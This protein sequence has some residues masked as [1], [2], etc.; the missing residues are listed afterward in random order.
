MFFPSS[1]DPFKSLNQ[2]EQL[3]RLEESQKAQTDQLGKDQADLGRIKQAADLDKAALAPFS[4]LPQKKDE[5]G[6]EGESSFDSVKPHLSS[7]SFVHL[8][9]ARVANQ[10]TYTERS[11]QSS[12]SYPV[13][14]ASVGIFQSVLNWFS[15]FSFS[16]A[17]EATKAHVGPRIHQ[18]MENIESQHF[19][20]DGDGFRKAVQKYAA[21]EASELAGLKKGKDRL[22][23]VGR[24][25]QGMILRFVAEKDPSQLKEG[26]EQSFTAFLYTAEKGSEGRQSA[27]LKD[28]KLSV[29]PFY[30]FQKIPA[31]KLYYER[32]ENKELYSSTLAN[33]ASLSTR[34]VSSI[35]AEDSSE[36]F[37]LLEDLLQYQV[38]AD[39]FISHFMRQQRSEISSQKSLNG[40][41]LHLCSELY[42]NEVEEEE[43]SEEV[44]KNQQNQSRAE[45]RRLTLQSRLVSLAAF[46]EKSQDLLDLPE[47]DHV[48]K[49]LRDGANNLLVAIYKYANHVD[50]EGKPLL[51]K[52]AA[53]TLRATALAVQER[54]E[55]A[56]EKALAISQQTY[57]AIKPSLP[58]NAAASESLGHY[59][60]IGAGAGYYVPQSVLSLPKIPSFSDAE[61]IIEEIDTYTDGLIPLIQKAEETDSSKVRGYNH[62]QVALLSSLEQLLFQIPDPSDDF[63]STSFAK[64]SPKDQKTVLANIQYFHEIYAQTLRRNEV[65]VERGKTVNSYSY[66]RPQTA[67][68]QVALLNFYAITHRIAVAMDRSQG[69]N[70]LED[71]PVD[72][73][74]FKKALEKDFT[75]A[76]DEVQL[77]EKRASLFQYF[78]TLSAQAKGDARNLFS[79]KSLSLQ[80]QKDSADRILYER[81]LKLRNK[82]D[83][84]DQKNPAIVNWGNNLFIVSSPENAL[85]GALNLDLGEPLHLV[86]GQGELMVSEIVPSLLKEYPHI[87]YLKKASIVNATL[88]APEA[89]SSSKVDFSESPQVHHDKLK[90]TLSSQGLNIEKEPSDD[91]KDASM[92]Y[93]KQDSDIQWN[94]VTRRKKNKYYGYDQVTESSALSLKTAYSVNPSQHSSQNEALTKKEETIQPAKGDQ[95]DDQWDPLAW[96]LA[97]LVSFPGLSPLNLLQWIRQHPDVLKSKEKREQIELLFFRPY[98]DSSGKEQIALFN[99]LKSEPEHI[100]PQ[101]RTF[102]SESITR[103]YLSKPHQRPDVESLV[104][105]LRFA[106]RIERNYLSIH[107]Q[108]LT[109]PLY[110]EKYLEE[111]FHIH[112]EAPPLTDSE[113]SRLS[114]CQFSHYF[115]CIDP[116]RLST[117]DLVK[118][119]KAWT[120]ISR[121]GLTEIGK[122]KDYDFKQTDE[123]QRG[124]SQLA[125]EFLRRCEE[126]ESFAKEFSDLIN[127]EFELPV[128]PQWAVQKKDGQPIPALMGKT[129]TG[130]WEMDLST[131][132]I[133]CNNTPLSNRPPSLYSSDKAIWNRLFGNRIFSYKKASSVYYFT[134]DLTYGSCRVIQ[135]SS[136]A[137]IERKLGDHW[138][139]AMHQSQINNYNYKFDTI[140]P[141][142]L[143][144]GYSHWVPKGDVKDVSLLICDLSTGKPKFIQDSQG[145]LHS[146]KVPSNWDG[147]VDALERTGIV[148]REPE[149]TVFHRLDK[150]AGN[151]FLALS[152]ET[153]EGNASTIRFER[154]FTP[155]GSRLRFFKKEGRWLYGPNPSWAMADPQVDGLFRHHNHYLLLH[156][157]DKKGKPTGRQ[158]IL[159]LQPQVKSSGP[160]NAETL[161]EASSYYK[162][163]S[164]DVTLPQGVSSSAYSSKI[165]FSIPLWNSKKSVQDQTLVIREFSIRDGSVTA[166]AVEDKLYLSLQLLAGKDY[167]GAMA[168][169]R[170]IGEA[171]SLNDA[172]KQFLIDLLC[173]EKSCKDQSP[174]ASAVRL[175]AAWVGKTLEPTMPLGKAV[176]GNHRALSNI[177]T[178]YLEGFQRVPADVALSPQEEKDLIAFFRLS[179][180]TRGRD[181]VLEGTQGYAHK[182]WK[183]D[184]KAL[185]T[186]TLAWEKDPKLPHLSYPIK[187]PGEAPEVGKH[188][189]QYRNWAAKQDSYNDNLKKIR[190]YFISTSEDRGEELPL[191]GDTTITMGMVRK[192]YN[193]L[194]DPQM[195]DREKRG[196]YDH[197]VHFFHGEFDSRNTKDEINIARLNLLHCAYTYGKKMPDFPS[198][199]EK[200]NVE[201]WEAFLNK[202][203]EN[204]SSALPGEQTSRP[205]FTFIKMGGTM[206]KK[207]EADKLEQAEGREASSQALSTALLTPK[208]ID[209]D[210]HDFRLTY[211]KD[212]KTVE[213]P[214]LKPLA[215]L[216]PPKLSKKDENVREAI[217]REFEK[218]NEDIQTS[219]DQEKNR[220]QY[221][222][223]DDKPLPEL[224]AALGEKLKQSKE[225]IEVKEEALVLL[226]KQKDVA[227]SPE[228]KGHIES[229]EIKDPSIHDILRASIKGTHEAYRALN[230]YL[231][232]ERIEE[233]HQRAIELMTYATTTQQLSGAHK[234]LKASEEALK[235]A[236]KAEGEEQKAL[237]A[238]ADTLKKEG[239]DILTATRNY[240]LENA[241]T[242]TKNI[243]LL[244]FEYKTGMRIRFKQKE[245]LSEILNKLEKGEHPP[246]LIFQLIMGGGKTSVILSFLLDYVA[247]IQGPEGESK[248]LST[249]MLD[250]ALFDGI[251]EN[252]K[253]YHWERFGKQLIPL[254]IQRENLQTAEDVKRLLDKI[255][256]AKREK[257]ALAVTSVDL[258]KILLELKDTAFDFNSSSGD[259]KKNVDLTRAQY[260]GEILCLFP[261]QAVILTDEPDLVYLINKKLIFSKGKA[262]HLSSGE[263]KTQRNLFAEIKKK[264][265]V[266]FS[267][268][269]AISEETYIEKVRPQLC[270]FS[271]KENKISPKHRASYT[272]YLCN[273]IKLSLERPAM[274]D[275][276]PPEFADLAEANGGED[277]FLN[278]MRTH[279]D[280]EWLETLRR[281]ANLD[282]GQW[283]ALKQDVSDWSYLRYLHVELGQSGSGKDLEK[284]NAQATSRFLIYNVLKGVL[285]K[286]PNRHFGFDLE[287]NGMIRPFTG[288]DNPATTQLANPQEAGSALFY[289]MLVLG[290]QKGFVKYL[291]ETMAVAAERNAFYSG[292]FDLTEEAVKF[293]EMT[294]VSLSLARYGKGLDEATAFLEKEENFD[295]LLEFTSALVHIHVDYYTSFL[296]SDAY[297]IPEFG[298]AN[299]TCTGTPGS[300]DTFN[301]IDTK[302]LDKGTLGKIIHHVRSKSDNEEALVLDD[303]KDRIES[304]LQLIEDNDLNALMDRGGLVK[305]TRKGEKTAGETFARAYLERFIE[306]PKRQSFIFFDYTDPSTGEVVPGPAILKKRRKTAPDGKVSWVI[307]KKPISLKDTTAESLRNVGVVDLSTMFVFFSETKTTGIDFKLYPTC[308]GMVTI[309][310][311]EAQGKRQGEERTLQAILRMRGLFY[312]QQVQFV[313]AQSQVDSF[314]NLFEMG[315]EQEAPTTDQVFEFL[316]ANDG[317]QKPEMTT[318]SL[319]ERVGHCT[320]SQVGKRYAKLASESPQDL[321]AFAKKYGKYLYTTISD[322]ALHRVGHLEGEKETPQCI[323]ELIREERDKIKAFGDPE[324]ENAIHESLN[325]L[326]TVFQRLKEEKALT[327]KTA[328]PSKEFS[329]GNQMQVSMQQEQE[330]KAELTQEQEQKIDLE[331]F[332]E[333]SSFQKPNNYRPAKEK[334]WNI[335]ETLQG[336]LPLEAG[337]AIHRAHDYFKNNRNKYGRDYHLAFSKELNLFFSNNFTR[338]VADK[339]IAVFD[340]AHKKIRHLLVCP[341]VDG[342]PGLMA[343]SDQDYTKW[344]KQIQ[345]WKGECP[346]HIVDLDGQVS[347]GGIKDPKNPTACSLPPEIQDSEDYQRTLWFANFFNGNMDYLEGHPEQS[348]AIMREEIEGADHLLRFCYFG[349]AYGKNKERRQ[350]LISSRTLNPLLTPKGEGEFHFGEVLSQSF[351]GTELLESEVAKAELADLEPEHVPTLAKQ[352][353]DRLRD[354]NRKDLIQAIPKDFINLI[355]PEKAPLLSHTQVPFITNHG[356]ANNLSKEQLRS[357][358]GDEGIR[359]LGLINLKTFPLENIPPSQ[360]TNIAL[361]QWEALSQRE[362]EE[363][364]EDLVRD[365]VHELNDSYNITQLPYDLKSLLK[366]EQVQLLDFKL[367]LQ[368]TPPDLANHFSEDQWGVLGGE[369]ANEESTTAFVQALTSGEHIAK[370][371]PFNLVK[372]L[373]EE[374]IPTIPTTKRGVDVLENLEDDRLLEA[375]SKQ[376]AALSPERIDRITNGELAIQIFRDRPEKARDLQFHIKRLVLMNIEPQATLHPWFSEKEI[377]QV[378]EKTALL[379]IPAVHAPLFLENQWNLLR[380][381]KKVPHVK[382]LLRVLSGQQ[383]VD[384]GVPSSLYGLLQQSQVQDFPATE[385]GKA[386]LNQ[387]PD[388]QLHWAKNEQLRTVNEERVRSIKNLDLANRFIGLGRG[389]ELSLETKIKVLK[390]L[391]NPESVDWITEDELRTI[392]DA[393]L[394][395]KFKD[396][397]APSFT[398]NQWKSLS[399]HENQD[400]VKHFV[401]QL[402]GKQVVLNELPSD[403]YCYL[404]EKQVQEIPCDMGRAVIND[405]PE[406][407]LLLAKEEQLRVLEKETI[408]K[409]RDLNLVKRMLRIN[410]TFLSQKIKES[411]LRL[412][413]TDQVSKEELGD[414]S[415]ISAKELQDLNDAGLNRFL[416]LF[417]SDRA[418]DFLAAQWDTL[419]HMNRSDKIVAFVATLSGEEVTNLPLP[420]AFDDLLS[421]SQI[422]GISEKTDNGKTILNRLPDKKLLE[423]RDEQIAELND[424]RIGQIQSPQLAQRVPL[425]KRAALNW[426]QK[427]ALLKREERQEESSWISN[428]EIDRLDASTIL[429]KLSF[430]RAN[431]FSEETWQLLAGESSDLKELKK[432]FVRELSP[433]KVLEVGLDPKLCAFLDQKQ[434]RDINKLP[435]N[436]HVIDSLKPGQLDWIKE[437]YILLSKTRIQNVQDLRVAKRLRPRDRKHLSTKM[438]LDLLSN[439]G[440]PTHLDWISNEEL[441]QINHGKDLLKLPANR[442][443]ALQ[444]NQWELLANVPFAEHKQT[445]ALVQALSGENVLKKE[446]PEALK[447]NLSPSQIR[448]IEAQNVPSEWFDSL[449]DEQLYQ[450]LNQTPVSLSQKR[451]GEIRHVEL[452]KR[453]PDNERVLLSGPMKIQLAK[454][455]ENWGESSKDWI[456]TDLLNEL[457]AETLRTKA[458]TERAVE[459]NSATWKKLSPLIPKD[460]LSDFFQTLSV[461]QIIEKKVPERFVNLYLNTEQVQGIDLTSPEQNSF[462]QRLNDDK[463]LLARDEQL[464]KLDEERVREIAN[465][466]L[467]K[468]ML[469]IQRQGDLPSEMKYLLLREKKDE[470]LFG[471][472][473]WLNTEEL[474]ALNEL[475]LNHHL[476]LC[477]QERAHEFLPEQWEFLKSLVHL[478]E[479]QS[480]FCELTGEEV[481][482][483][484]I[485]QEYDFYLTYDQIRGIPLNT[486]NGKQLLN[487][488]EDTRLTDAKREQLSVLSEERIA[489]IDSLQLAAKIPF[490]KRISLKEDLKI[491]FLK[492]EETC[493][494]SSWIRNEELNRLDARLILEKIPSNRAGDLSAEKWKELSK[495]ENTITNLLFRTKTDPNAK[496]AL[497]QVT[498]SLKAGKGP[499]EV[500][501][502]LEQKDERLVSKLKDFVEQLSPQQVIDKDLPKEVCAHLSKD[503]VLGVSKLP[504]HHQ[505]LSRLTPDQKTWIAEKAPTSHTAASPRR[506]KRIK[507]AKKVREK[508][509]QTG[510]SPAKPSDKS[511]GK[512]LKQQPPLFSN[513]QVKKP[514][515]P[516]VPPAVKQP[517]KS[518]PS[519]ISK[520]EAFVRSLISGSKT[521]QSLS[522]EEWNTLGSLEDPRVNSFIQNMDEQ[523]VL[524]CLPLLPP[525]VIQTLGLEQTKWIPETTN[526]GKRA[527]NLFTDQQLLYGTKEGAISVL[528]DD[529]IKAIRSVQVLIPKVPTSR[530]GVLRKETRIQILQ[531]A[532]VQTQIP[533]ISRDDLQSITD[534]QT[535]ATKIPPNRAKDLTPN[536]WKILLSNGTGAHLARGL[537]GAEV[538]SCQ[539][540]EAYYP[541]LLPDQ[542][543]GIPY[544][545]AEGQ[546]V[547]NKLSDHKLS[548][549]LSEQIKVLTPTR[550]GKITQLHIAYKA[551]QVGK[552]GELSS[553]TRILVL[554]YLQVPKEGQLDVSW[555]TTEDLRSI[556][557]VNILISKIPANRSR[558]FTPAQWN[559]LSLYPQN[560]KVQAFVQALTGREVASRVASKQIPLALLGALTPQQVKGIPAST[561]NGKL[562]L[563]QLPPEKLRFLQKSQINLAQESL[564]GRVESLNDT[565]RNQVLHANKSLI[566]ILKSSDKINAISNDLVNSLNRQQIKQ[567]NPPK[568]KYINPNRMDQLSK[569]Q[570][571]KLLG[572]EDVQNKPRFVAQIHKRSKVKAVPKHLLKHLPAKRDVIKGVS[573][574]RLRYLKL[575]QLN[576]RYYAHWYNYPL[577]II[578]GVGILAATPLELFGGICWH[579]AKMTGLGISRIWNRSEERKESVKKEAYRT[580]I[581]APFKPLLT[582]FLA[583]FHY[584]AYKMAASHF[585]PG[586]KNYSPSDD[587]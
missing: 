584:S 295:H 90:I 268:D 498:K 47:G 20:L 98:I 352:A 508:K 10:T 324:L 311:Q 272:R 154:V 49:M 306:D 434:V 120:E 444:K 309:N 392:E 60:T 354:L 438:K 13:H 526:A 42:E 557:N 469:L 565:R 409:I 212:P 456:S 542:I 406:D 94:S 457:E 29:K 420:Q 32:G 174:E 112:K 522:Q 177:Y 44:K 331:L 105:V 583:P 9:G 302:L 475:D 130:I 155:D 226:A 356:I 129:S 487:R 229:Y 117:K 322:Q 362:L 347:A 521:A 23:A 326:D 244:Y 497:D 351:L 371:L 298:L 540:P 158:K 277:S 425:K 532:P 423:S 89:S 102:V 15:S 141:Q 267:A 247:E 245:L 360:A 512:P 391:D 241:E 30:A 261:E 251:F 195:S 100:L 173:S 41:L 548:N 539:L 385:K 114:L 571:S 134:D 48:R 317:R 471:D 478:P 95:K 572:R 189:Q 88:M 220:E 294:G 162:P 427:S 421:S 62:A 555:V 254:R 346:Y 28:A 137:S 184:N 78:D 547:I 128:N 511:S 436:E 463:L 545:T 217:E 69:T 81:I 403:L 537:T 236:Q 285:T 31:S 166:D 355:L 340:P 235:E 428:E 384:N 379:R 560:P 501:Q 284:A 307:D 535:L 82:K 410:P 402:S 76:I 400:K 349:V 8:H 160:N 313:V 97:E 553:E 87:S 394:L 587:S 283:E 113:F 58:K 263:I 551:C 147:H 56:E 466:A 531:H 382:E 327:Q 213:A 55:E 45:F 181:Q 61:K 124:G 449:S 505:I 496:K 450:G 133:L 122:G 165:S 170:T 193:Q 299:I 365:L 246:Q 239:V 34:S 197:M 38:D 107:N 488:L 248:Y 441:K 445:K 528:T 472:L 168:T 455:L 337:V 36:I 258:Q 380:D 453:I 566:S 186:P 320:I 123:A 279:Y 515:Q 187:D 558:E 516:F 330:E 504:D 529:R 314:K 483:L 333:R 301:R 230:P 233:I 308:K 135:S 216:T 132:R 221:E 74:L 492:L 316:I 192:F 111:L 369:F 93:C 249:L 289:C 152:K 519:P 342:K 274:G 458:P 179:H 462:F 341:N 353:P 3:S 40:L 101:I 335:P 119:T 200:D 148:L 495:P 149:K 544:D 576:A 196:I 538:V 63:W 262:H 577:N 465:D 252:V 300:S 208:A 46:C 227:L 96:D 530:F 33:L 481:A 524:D 440:S 574:D 568:I 525:K 287:G 484:S 250:P 499:E 253:R 210:L 75:H 549:A 303:S 25:G 376:R 65:S 447:T 381:F 73:S 67:R 176:D 293:K 546:A 206:A 554:A 282:E 161:Y 364:E 383:V 415:W 377:Q 304:F 190:R 278:D 150:K 297:D 211:F 559:S 2:E 288:R 222:L 286:E 140:V 509:L 318:R 219:I 424:V 203:Y 7:S 21:N 461:E 275:Q 164:R 156:E 54:V 412:T 138:F 53:N 527:I 171:D 366:P 259:S 50:G 131:G 417:P 142:P 564:R 414:L 562:L 404:G 59:K 338:T 332:N 64:L 52:Q 473:S 319:K 80:P 513:K 386:S 446:L 315:E 296:S 18:L 146:V 5:E 323:E 452:A 228:K 435:G 418:H 367:C 373:S 139:A 136:K 350:Q 393:D 22:I 153:E 517:S 79:W 439:L 183:F 363:G 329:L 468:R 563:S 199:E 265:L 573:K 413:E 570:I 182:Q 580:F 321:P 407:R 518:Q 92:P 35:Q 325:Q 536:Q 378:E 198:F 215:P 157:L 502:D 486:E 372:H 209:A 387:L 292:G 416:P 223:K 237:Q 357:L 121:R 83:A 242:I 99:Q 14:R 84:E 582:N 433:E 510:K 66:N 493:K 39:P 108:P 443:P 467:A 476:P 271:I 151:E 328:S 442:A 343:L 395:I 127:E 533:W 104:F 118:A 339:E 454:E 143:R 264:H 523:S 72:V 490:E 312:G 374:Q 6:E 491:N 218:C 202:V 390:T 370:I 16:F 464:G 290:P 375:S 201:A 68:Q 578:K 51:S 534:V 224:V 106:Q 19:S 291:A 470:K 514:V 359:V 401:S 398:P 567:L 37:R 17:S 125:Q 194:K 503:Q 116:S 520:E 266:D 310:T 204:A 482:R 348:A 396:T 358:E 581:T 110:D 240:S 180:Q 1:S 426:E 270:K 552:V 430:D 541:Y 163:Q 232:D 11:S 86:S 368:T 460:R 477:S 485:P 205:G 27:L 12:L 345:N 43:G 24:P 431:D 474:R 586:S 225:A 489:V 172:S 480:L 494:D 234:K 175:R 115:P 238:E 269:N 256:R 144:I 569:D 145:R 257:N 479:V 91:S 185:H 451:V 188:T 305:T 556:R 4:I 388:R 207:L 448:E 429:N 214:D 57:D 126:E 344:K 273:E 109:P 167:A 77:L 432:V 459:F 399:E 361:E 405:L 506:T 191:Y 422:Q 70:L 397:R 255:K 585:E 336:E 281:P 550:V 575:K 231:S 408:A 561:D 159:M 411:L 260:L 280:K 543:K 419:R 169:L 389:Q 103:Y 71:L 276:L 507:K 500:I 243:R 26:E 85:L 178:S 334:A 437:H 579:F